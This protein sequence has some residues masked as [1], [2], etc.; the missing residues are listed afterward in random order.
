M[1]KFIFAVVSVATFY[2]S[3]AFADPP[4]SGFKFIDRPVVNKLDIKPL[5]TNLFRTASQSDPQSSSAGLNFTGISSSGTTT[6]AH[7]MIDDSH[8]HAKLGELLPDGSKLISIDLGGGNITTN[9]NNTFTTYTL[10]KYD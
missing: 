6:V 4:P 10:A 7:F 3:P 1:H 2:A 9:K 5:F 8:L